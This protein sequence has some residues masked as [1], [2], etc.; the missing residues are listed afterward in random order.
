MSS[1]LAAI[2]RWEELGRQLEKTVDAYLDSCTGLELP[3]FNCTPSAGEL[4]SKVED[5]LHSFDDITNRLGSARSSLVRTRNNM[6]AP[7]LR[8]PNE[9]LSRIFDLAIRI[10]DIGASNELSADCL[11]RTR[12]HALH[13]LLG[14]CS[15]WQQVG[16]SQSRLWSLIPVIR[17][18]DDRLDW[19]AAQLSLDRAIGCGLH[20]VAE[21]PFFRQDIQ[22]FIH[23]ALNE[24]G[25]RI[26]SINLQTD[27]APLLYGA[28]N[29]FI[30]ATSNSTRRL[31]DLSMCFRRFG[32]NHLRHHPYLCRPEVPGYAD[33]NHMLESLR[34]LRL[35]QVNINFRDV[36]FRSLTELRLQQVALG[37]NAKLVESLLSISSSPELRNLEII[38]VVTFGNTA[39]STLSYS[40]ISFPGLHRLYLEDLYQDTLN[41][42]LAL[43]KPGSHRLILHLTR[44]CDRICRALDPYLAQQVRFRG[45]RLQDFQV[46]TL[47][48]GSHFGTACRANFRDVLELVP[49]A[50]SFYIDSRC[51][52][53]DY[54]PNMTSPVD[55]N[56]KNSN[57]TR[58]YITRSSIP[59]SNIGALKDLVASH[60]IEELG[61][62]ISV[63]DLG[64]GELV[65]SH[66]LQSPHE[67]LDPIRNWILDVVPRVVWLSAYKP[68]V[69]EFES[70]I[71]QLW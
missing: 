52:S 33:F 64:G 26:G 69:L 13:N 34:V 12:Y 38:S 7:I 59:F 45:L 16:V 67:Q 6:A 2:T 49:T 15:K 29:A 31:H 25:P 46:D 17:H 40:S 43:V 41:L 3:I 61:I 20:L 32:I 71:W 30:Q 9:I 19:A 18:M 65:D 55:P 47:M 10:V 8:L 44:N 57:L 4:V 35:R 53:P 50:T 36:S 11:T 23:D 37:S 66:D 62:G 42:L 1:S 63:T 70:D 54:L 22:L 68:S 5:R 21:L 58:L 14:V 39:G 56:S 28:I 51:L 24:Y 60:P 27:V 48:L